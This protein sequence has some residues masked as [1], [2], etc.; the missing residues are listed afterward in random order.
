MTISMPHLKIKFPTP[1]GVA[2]CAG[3]KKAAWDAYLKALRGNRVCVVD[4]EMDSRPGQDSSPEEPT[5][6]VI[7]DDNPEHTTRVGS[8]M[9]LELTTQLVEF[10]RANRDIFAWSP[11]DMPGIDPEVVMHHL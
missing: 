6:E 8:S 3:D 1:N 10:L 4:S 2:I 9:A 11:A 5:E 7:L